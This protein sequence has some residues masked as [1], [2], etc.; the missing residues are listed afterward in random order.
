MTFVEACFESIAP[1]RRLPEW[2]APG[3]L[4]AYWPEVLVTFIGGRQRLDLDAKR[5]RTELET[6]GLW[7]DDVQAEVE[8][9]ALAA[10]D[11]ALEKARSTPLAPDAMLDHCYTTDTQ[12]LARQRAGL[13]AEAGPGGSAR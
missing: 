13:L 4:V 3:G 8:E 10:L 11:A 1:A 12:R 7:D 2:Y 9:A 5:L 6:A